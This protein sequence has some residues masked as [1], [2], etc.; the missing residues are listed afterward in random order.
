MPAVT[1]GYLSR[2][3]DISWSSDQNL[4]LTNNKLKSRAS[5]FRMPY[6]FLNCFRLV[7][8]VRRVTL[9]T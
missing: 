9:G 1:M 2:K 7:L 8:V 6:L 4:P 3:G 5:T